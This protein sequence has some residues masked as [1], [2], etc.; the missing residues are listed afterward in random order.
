M[1]KSYN[2][3]P[4]IVTEKDGM[5]LLYTHDGKMIG[6]VGTTRVTQNQELSSLGRADVIAIFPACPVMT[7]EEFDKMFSK[8]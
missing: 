3:Q 5:Q 8:E 6:G 7:R 1:A 2:R 4:Y